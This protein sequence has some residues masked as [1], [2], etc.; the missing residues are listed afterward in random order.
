MENSH[1]CI[2]SRA[3]SAV[4]PL[5]SLQRGKGVIQINKEVENYIIKR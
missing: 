2:A 5:S 4:Q 1:A 3:V